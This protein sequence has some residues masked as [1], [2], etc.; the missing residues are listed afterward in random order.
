MKFTRESSGTTLVRSVSAAGIQIGNE[1]HEHTIGLVA[2]TV[3]DDWGDKSVVALEEADLERLLA[4]DPEVVI[5]G[6]GS[7]NVFP[8]RELVFA[9]ARRQVGLEVMDTAAAAR[10]YNVLAS[11]GRRVAAL[12]YSLNQGA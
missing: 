4:H 2:D 3:V 8:P 1:L 10:T 7:S 6:T 9:M 5:L 11:E 12:L